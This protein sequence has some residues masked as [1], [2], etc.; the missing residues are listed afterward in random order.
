MTTAVQAY[1]L[2]RPTAPRSEYT[3]GQQWYIYLFHAM[4]MR[5]KTARFSANRGL[6]SRVRFAT[7]GL[8]KLRYEIHVLD[9][10][11]GFSED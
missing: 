1:L 10:G 5:A 7:E 6:V 4:H 2:V 8:G 9:L 3:A 11:M